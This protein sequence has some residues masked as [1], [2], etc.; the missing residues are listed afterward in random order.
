M[1]KV[2]SIVLTLCVICAFSVCAFAAEI[3]QSNSDAIIPVYL[4]STVDGTEEGELTPTALS[5]TVPT[6]L[7][8]VMNQNGDVTTATDC[9]ITN[10][11]Y[12]AVRVKTVIISAADGWNLTPFGDKS[13]LAFE[14]VDSN[15]LGFAMKIGGGK[16]VCTADNESAQQLIGGAIEGC[17]MAGVGSTD[18]NSVSVEYSAIVTPISKAMNQVAIA[19]VTFVVEWDTVD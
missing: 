15:K 18:L 12:G 7:P 19:N 6:S 13:T 1:K 11:S 14:K 4:T 5:V 17:Y 2:I 9:K 10:N 8:M 16:Q 3:N